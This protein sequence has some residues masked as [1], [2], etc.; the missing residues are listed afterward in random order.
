MLFSRKTKNLIQGCFVLIALMVSAGIAMGQSITNVDANQEGKSIA[1][2]YDLSE[3]TDISLYITQDGGKTKTPIPLKFISGDVGRRIK[4]GVQKKILWRVLDQ[5]PNQGFQ[6]ENISFIV[7]GSPRMSFFATLNAGYSLD[8]GFNAGFMAGQLGTIGWYV[9]GMTTLSF[10]QSA[11]YECD[12]NGYIDYIMPAYSG[13]ASVFKAYGVA[14]IAFR[15]SDP[16]Y[17]N[18]GA[19]YGARIYEWELTSGQWVKNLPGSYGGFALDA[20]VIGRLGSVVLSA[21]V[22]LL[23]KGNVDICLGVGYVF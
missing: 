12:E 5:Y 18:V 1:I 20:G 22:T 23:L 9:K 17:V 13:Q 2:T 19:G 14:G 15:L 6:G 11:E 21:G 8:P 10:P 16:L 4:P 3:T 7:K